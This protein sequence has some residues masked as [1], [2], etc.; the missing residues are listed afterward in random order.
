[1]KHL[2]LNYGR[3]GD[4]SL[5][6]W[7]HRHGS[8]SLLNTT[9]LES[10]ISANKLELIFT[11]INQQSLYCDQL[12]KSRILTKIVVT[13]CVPVTTHEHNFVKIIG[14]NMLVPWHC[15]FN[16][17]SSSAVPIEFN[18]HYPCERPYIF[19]F[20]KPFWKSH[21]RNMGLVMHGLLCWHIT[22]LCM[23]VCI[24]CWTIGSWAAIQYK[25]DILP[26]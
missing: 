10:W 18:H 1:M 24:T 21:L 15:V 4:C 6:V 12:F 23:H 22:C 26:V 8:F 13:H 3:C 14:W 11:L 16:P 5:I 17:D 2:W 20:D 19:P 7:L 9:Q 25:D